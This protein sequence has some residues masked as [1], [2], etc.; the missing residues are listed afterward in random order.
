MN[1]YDLLP[2]YGLTLEML[3]MAPVLPKTHEEAILLSNLYQVQSTMAKMAAQQELALRT[4]LGYPTYINHHVASPQVPLPSS[5]P[6][7]S[8]LPLPLPSP[9][10]LPVVPSASSLLSFS[11]I[12]FF[13]QHSSS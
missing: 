2:N 6:L 13:F 8:P 7:P 3:K 4:N 10:P 9:L 5:L 1:Y 12:D 11:E